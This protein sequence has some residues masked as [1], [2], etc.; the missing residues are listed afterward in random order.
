MLNKVT[1]IG[2]K[3]EE[4][5]KEAGLKLP[6]IDYELMSKQAYATNGMCR[7]FR[8]KPFYAL[9]RINPN[10]KDIEEVKE[11]IAHELAH[12][13]IDSRNKGHND[14]WYAICRKVYKVVG[15]DPSKV[16]R[17]NNRSMSGS[18]LKFKMTEK[19]ASLQR[20]NSIYKNSQKTHIVNIVNNRQKKRYTDLEN[21]GIIQIISQ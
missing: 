20:K 13:V 8:D 1:T 18:E 16:S 2:K 4:L 12:A 3:Y 14:R 15:L 7:K 11:I 10:L 5:I 6:K 9:I 21:S 17:T 19:G